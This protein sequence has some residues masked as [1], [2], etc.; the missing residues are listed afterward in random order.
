MSRGVPHLLVV[1]AMAGAAASIVSGGC[2]SSSGAGAT[3]TPPATASP[4][5]TPFPTPA[6]LANGQASPFALAAGNGEVFWSTEGDG[7]IWRLLAAGGTPMA[8]ATYAAPS[9]AFA[10]DAGYLYV[11][12][13]GATPPFP[14]WKIPRAGGTPTA[15]AQTGRV[16]GI[17]VDGSQAYWTERDTGNVLSVS[18]GG[19]TPFAFATAQAVPLGI[20][21]QPFWTYWAEQG[22]GS[23][24]REPKISGTP[25]RV[26]QGFT[27]IFSLTVASGYIYFLEE[28]NGRLCRIAAGG[29]NV[30]SAEVLA[31]G[32]AQP[33]YF[34][35]DGTT[36]YWA[37]R[38]GGSVA[39]LPITAGTGVEP[40]ASG[41][42]DP[43]QVAID[44]SWLYWTEHQGARVW[45][46]LR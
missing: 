41:L 45:R 25:E 20:A 31:Q 44:G 29:G 43:L 7:A 38:G 11:T 22:T 2:S 17:T 3:F 40:L 9:H 30:G 4:T 10:L 32:L 35:C 36:A 39:R 12:F 13:N 37:E 26:A 15:I 28:N 6:L 18:L 42:N 24:W 46:T 5:P 34:W 14:L 21:D 23:F 16:E 8:F 27:T 33:R 1:C 19:G